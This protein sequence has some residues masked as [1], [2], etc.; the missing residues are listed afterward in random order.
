M[1]CRGATGPRQRTREAGRFESGSRHPRKACRTAPFAERASERLTG[2]NPPV[3]LFLP[4]QRLFAAKPRRRSRDAASSSRASHARSRRHPATHRPP[5]H[6]CRP[7]RRLR[8]TACARAGDP[9]AR[10]CR[11]RRCVAPRSDARH[12]RTRSGP[13]R[14]QRRHRLGAAAPSRPAR[15]A[16][17]GPGLPRSAPAHGSPRRRTATR[18]VHHA[19][20]RR[21]GDLRLLPLL[22]PRLRGYRRGRCGRG[23][24]RGRMRGRGAADAHRPRKALNF[25]EGQIAGARL[26]GVGS[27]AVVVTPG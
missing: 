7:P 8:A 1:R 17:G 6:A 18:T 3:C 16:R 15:R 25:A 21:R 10:G 26:I 19:L 23:A 27:Y 13:H 9:P 20:G 14:R 5:R 22:C 11:R 2:P 12:V 24:V 4:F